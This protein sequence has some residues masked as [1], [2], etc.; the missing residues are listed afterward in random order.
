MTRLKSVY[1][2][3][4]TQQQTYYEP[5]LAALSNNN[6][7]TDDTLFEKEFNALCQ[8]TK[9]ARPRLRA[10]IKQVQ[11]DTMIAEE[12]YSEKKQLSISSGFDRLDQMLQE[13]FSFGQVNEICAETNAIPSRLISYILT[14]Y[15]MT[16][17]IQSVFVFD[18]TGMLEP[19]SMN[20]TFIKRNL[21]PQLLENI[22]CTQSFALSDLSSSLENLAA[23]LSTS[24]NTYPLVVIDDLARLI[25]PDWSIQ[26]GKH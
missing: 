20:D 5:V 21:D 7:M 26:A 10:F 13:G 15:L 11:F 22:D 23:I 4:N 17:S 25:G 1:N 9:I 3:W 14:S 2:K 6:I 12:T 24:E 18:T 19:R 8:L 16:Y